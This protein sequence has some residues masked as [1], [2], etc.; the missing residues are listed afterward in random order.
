[1]SAPDFTLPAMIRTIE[2]GAF[3]GIDAEIVYIPD[4]CTSIGRGAFRSCESLTQ[5]RVP[6]GCAIGEGA[7]DGCG[8]VFVF[9]PAGS[10]AQT[11]CADPAN[12]NCI[13]IAG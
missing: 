9:A 3:E 5:I 6:V 12:P 4:G 10:P 2:D 7:F 8:T 1:M 11:F 13:F